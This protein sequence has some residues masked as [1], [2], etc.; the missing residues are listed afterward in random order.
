MTDHPAFLRAILADP[1][2]DTPRLV[3]ADWLDERD[4]PAE[5]G[6]AE[7]LRLTAA[8]ASADGDVRLR[9]LAA[10]LDPDWLAVVSKLP[11]EICAGKWEEWTR[12]AVRVRFDFV[13]DRRWEDLRATPDPAVRHCDG[14]RQDVHYCDSITVARDHARQ[15][16][17]VAV[18]L[19]VI[20]RDND[21]RMPPM[22]RSTVGVPSRDPDGWRREEELRKPDPVSAERDRR[23]ADRASGERG[24]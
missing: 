3:Y 12:A 21:L 5:A 2:D 16:R 6:M 14:C 10:G 11:V 24:A 15:R 8:P 7:F 9:E 4:D 20:R 22:G 23:R 19:G 1:A 17:C 13:C 18:D